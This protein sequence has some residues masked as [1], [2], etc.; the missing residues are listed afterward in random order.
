MGEHKLPKRPAE[1]S[2]PRRAGTARAVMQQAQRNAKVGEAKVPCNGCSECCY[3]EVIGVNPAIESPSSLAHLDLEPYPAGGAG[4]PMRVRKR[5]DGACVHLGEH[6]CTVWQYRPTVCRLYDCRVYSMLGV[7]DRF[8]GGRRN[9]DWQF[10][11]GDP[12]DQAFH[13]GLGNAAQDFLAAYP[14]SRPGDVLLFV[15]RSV[16]SFEERG[17][18]WPGDRPGS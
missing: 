7:P 13:A 18:D 17:E 9:P 12:E 5:D 10:A 16:I 3:S 4:D 8:A 14:G 6:G 11:R 1:L 15:V 2:N